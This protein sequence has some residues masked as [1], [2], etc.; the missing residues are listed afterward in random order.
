MK[1]ISGDERIRYTR[2]MMMPEIGEHGQ[3]KLKAARVLI[4]GL[5][6][7]GSIH[8]YY[9]AAAGIGHIKI[10]DMDCVAMGNLN[11]Q[12]LHT[13]PDIGRPKTESAREKIAAL[14][15]HC[16]IEIIG[17]KITADNASEIVLGNHVILDATD[18]LEARTALNRASVQ[19]RIPFVYGG[20]D[21]F[22]GMVSTFMPNTKPCLS[23]L[24]SEIKKHPRGVGVLGP[25]AGLIGAIQSLEAIKLLLGLEASLV[26]RLLHVRGV[27][28]SF[29][30]ITIRKN[31]ACPVCGEDQYLK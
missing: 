28:M 14:N 19:N 22:N 18:N 8:A 17:E 10:A 30:E 21:G 25:V 11:R 3:Q 15:P 9:M 29:K 5:G 31:P 24:F 16:R 26:G 6:G 27:D 4:A 23:C 13:T 12:I 2:Q 20:I 7:L 1:K